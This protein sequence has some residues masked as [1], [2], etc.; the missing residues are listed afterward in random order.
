MEKVWHLV[1]SIPQ[2][3][4]GNFSLVRTGTALGR[5]PQLPLHVL[6]DKPPH[7]LLQG[8]HIESMYDKLEPEW[9]YH[10]NNQPA[11]N[12]K[13][14]QIKSHLCIQSP[15][16]LTYRKSHSKMSCPRLTTT[17]T[18]TLYISSPRELLCGAF[19]GRGVKAGWGEF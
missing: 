12:N 6:P 15:P 11:L 13:S 2:A 1:E 8:V 4:H 3:R 14:N 10:R 9:V 5:P 17:W 18:R 16:S 19:W 7:H